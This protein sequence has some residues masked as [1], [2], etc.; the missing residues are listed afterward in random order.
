MKNFEQKTAEQKLLNSLKLGN[1]DA[2][3]YIFNLYYKDLVLFGATILTDKSKVEDIVQSVFLKLWDN[4]TELQ[5]EISLKSYLLKAVQNSCL[6]TL[7]RSRIIPM[8][9][10]EDTILADN[11][12][13]HDTE[14][15]IL[16][17]ELLQHLDAAI[18]KLPENYRNVFTLG[19]IKD[20][21]YSEIS[22]YLLISER[23]VELR[24]SKALQL[25][26]LYLK[27]FLTLLLFFI[28]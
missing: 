26:R 8:D 3:A 16:Y 7:K 1:Q 5:I 28:Y 25:I 6:D 15:Y 20:M 4:R 21:K 9:L 12:L 13:H 11:L 22:N 27:E 10:I 23:T 18:E 14:D 24:M 2:F 19:K 17:S